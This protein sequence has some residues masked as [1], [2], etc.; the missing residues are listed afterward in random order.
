MEKSIHDVRR[1]IT[2]HDFRTGGS[3]IQVNPMLFYLY[4]SLP[5]SLI[6]VAF[7]IFN[8][9]IKNKYYK[10]T[11]KP[12]EEKRIYNDLKLD[13]ENIL[14]ETNP[15]KYINKICKYDMANLSKKIKQLC[16]NNVFHLF[17][18]GGCYMFFLERDFG[19]WKFFNSKACITP[20]IIKKILFLHRD[21]V[22]RMRSFLQAKDS[23]I[24]DEIIERKF[25]DFIQ[26]LIQKMNPEVLNKFSVLCSGT[27]LDDIK[28]IIWDINDD[29]GL[30]HDENFLKRLPPTV[31]EKM[32]KK[33]K[34]KSN[35]VDLEKE[36]DPVCVNLGKRRR[37]RNTEES[38]AVIEGPDVCNWKDNKPSNP[39]K[40]SRNFV[41][42]YRSFIRFYSNQKLDG[43][44]V[45][46]YS[47]DLDVKTA[48]EILDLLKENSRLDMLFIQKWMEYF[49]ETYLKGKKVSYSENVALLKLKNIFE[50]F[51]QKFY[52][53]HE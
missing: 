17:A 27:S 39:I 32:E 40:N 13:M 35:K 19:H 3:F 50:E 7:S 12:H 2:D 38:T 8:G 4:N 34:I 25:V 11:T 52:I 26:N 24:N 1:S 21:I 28:T 16:N 15:S 31:R 6:Q 45:N 18:I 22:V 14:F 41:R 5:K 51:N 30:E 44:S 36:L 33:M 9:I 42:Y 43:L 23:F 10:D 48:S 20:R 53:P 46:F 49:C 47:Y 29:M 37:T